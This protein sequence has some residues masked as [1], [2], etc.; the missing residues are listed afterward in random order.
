MGPRL[1]ASI[2]P[3]G[4]AWEARVYSAT[5]AL[6]MLICGSHT[7]VTRTVREVISGEFPAEDRSSGIWR[8]EDD[9]SP[10]F[11]NDEATACDQIER[12]GTK[13]ID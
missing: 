3:V 1:L 9:F 12:G 4:T 7:F 8:T 2:R 6:P 11:L 5:A 13:S 10:V